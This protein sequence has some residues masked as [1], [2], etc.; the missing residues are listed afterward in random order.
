M[1]KDRIGSGL[2]GR[3]D[4]GEGVVL[5]EGPVFVVRISG[6]VVLSTLRES[7]LSGCGCEFAG[8]GAGA[9]CEGILGLNVGAF[10]GHGIDL[11]DIS[12]CPFGLEVGVL[13]GNGDGIISA[14]H[15]GSG[16]RIGFILSARGFRLLGIAG[17]NCKSRESKIKQTFHCLND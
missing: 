9:F 4:H 3:N 16:V 10:C 14:G 11:E 8:S 2:L 1:G 7:G 12:F 15:I 17:K 13:Q 6:E 5:C